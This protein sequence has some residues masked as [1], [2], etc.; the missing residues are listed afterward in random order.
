MTEKDAVKCSQFNDER[1]FCLSVA[2]E[3]PEKFPRAF[4]Q[5]LEAKINSKYLLKT[6]R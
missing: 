3:I 6:R 2:L 4:F 5:Q 1:L